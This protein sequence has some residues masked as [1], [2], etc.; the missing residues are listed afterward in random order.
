MAVSKGAFGYL[1]GSIKQF[2]SLS[3]NKAFPAGT[4]WDLETSSPKE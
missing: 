3:A 1:N 4:P 2:P